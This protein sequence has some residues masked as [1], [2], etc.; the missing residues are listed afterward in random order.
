[1]RERE[2]RERRTERREGGQREG[3]TSRQMKGQTDERTNGWMDWD[4]AHGC[5]APTFP[6]AMQ[7]PPHL[8]S[9]LLA[10][11]VFYLLNWKLLLFTGDPSPEHPVCKV[12]S[13]PY[14]LWDDSV[15][16][17]CV[18]LEDGTQSALIARASTF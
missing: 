8:S 3:G 13:L 18:D 10:L 6:V 2:R 5:C 14:N 17:H 4:T 1:M 16:F 15:L 7:E 11:G 9:S 12:D